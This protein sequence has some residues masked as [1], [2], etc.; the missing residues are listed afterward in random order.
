MIFESTTITTKTIEEKSMKSNV[1]G[2]L[3]SIELINI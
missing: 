3:R 1:A 2:S